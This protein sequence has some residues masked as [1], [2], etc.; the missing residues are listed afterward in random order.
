MSDPAGFDV[1][2]AADLL[3]RTHGG[4]A[5]AVARRRADHRMLGG[6]PGGM[7][8]WCLV[9]KTIEDRVAPDPHP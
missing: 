2:R 6:D 3:L 9:A 7:L 5:V 1:D 8:A 4:E